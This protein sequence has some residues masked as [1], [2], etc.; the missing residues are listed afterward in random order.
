[1]DE[2]WNLP[3]R[4]DGGNAAA[5]KRRTAS[6]APSGQSRSKHEVGTT[7]HGLR[8]GR[9]RRAIAPPVA[10]PHRPEGA[11]KRERRNAPCTS[12]PPAIIQPL[13]LEG[14]QVFHNFLI[15]DPRLPK[16]VL[17]PCRLG[18]ETNRVVKD[19][20]CKRFV[21][22]TSRRSDPL[23]RRYITTQNR[24][25]ESSQVIRNRLDAINH[26]TLIAC[27]EERRFLVVRAQH[28]VQQVTEVVLL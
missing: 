16:L 6:V 18:R 14:S 25:S 23:I 8:D 9:L 27:L 7:D 5:P 21:L 1:M 13:P 26:A 15:Q 12:V 28:D 3:S 4:R 2:E 11:K 19:L 17:T 22:P 10:T 20:L 24:L